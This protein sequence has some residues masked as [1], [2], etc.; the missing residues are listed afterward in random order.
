MLTY[1][2]IPLL[3]HPANIVLLDDDR[4][5]LNDMCFYIDDKIPYVLETDQNKLLNYL[6]SHTYQSEALTA[7]VSRPTFSNVEDKLDFS[8]AFIV[9]FSHLR[10]IDSANRFKKVIVVFVDQQ[11]PGMT[12]LEF[13][14]KVR[15]EGLAVKLILLTGQAG[16]D[17]AV[18]AFNENLIDGYLPK[19]D[20]QLKEKINAY[21]NNFSWQQFIELSNTLAGFLSHI[22]KPL[23]DEQFTEVFTK[24]CQSNNINEFYLLDST[25]SFLMLD[26]KGHAKQFLVRNE[27]DYEDCYTMAKD[28]EAP[29]DVLQALRGRQQFPLTRESMGYIKLKGD[30]WD[31]AMIAMTKVPGRELYYA[32]VDRPDVHSLSFERYSGEIWPQP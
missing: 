23:Y 8:E 29:Y 3:Y 26:E 20:F 31:D 30:A 9:D 27:E 21:A 4:K 2:R 10:N 1:P 11:M 6:Q 32:I 7:L 16:A 19:S 14:K 15:A 24:T 5:F 28:S 13:C 22:M 18:K 12:G 17:A 25:C